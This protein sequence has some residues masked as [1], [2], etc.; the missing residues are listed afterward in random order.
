MGV[1]KQFFQQ[2]DWGTLDYLIV[3]LPPGTGDAQLTM[4]QSVDIDGA[5]VVT[6]PQKVAV[7][8]AVRGVEM[9]NKLGVSILGIVENMSYLTLPNGEKLRPFGEGGGLATAMEYNVPLIEQIPLNEEIRAGGD[10][11]MPV[12]L[13]DDAI[14]N[15]F[16]NIA[17][18]V[19]AGFEC[20]D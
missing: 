18:A 9:F 13:S 14:A 19:V 8:D 16:V 1:V 17:K 10:L 4:I 6:T 5:V 7:L 2:V 15:P 12:A 3:D 20:T 11:G